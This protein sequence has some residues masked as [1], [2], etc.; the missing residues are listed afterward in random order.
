MARGESSRVGPAGGCALVRLL[1]KAA[2][3]T[4]GLY[5]GVVWCERAQ[6]M[7]DETRANERRGLIDRETR[8]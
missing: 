7:C 6:L 4:G 2:H 5:W 1:G 3:K 8:G